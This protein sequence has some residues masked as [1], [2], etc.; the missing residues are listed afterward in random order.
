M[1]WLRVVSI[2][3]LAVAALQASAAAGPVVTTRAGA[4]RGVAGY[5]DVFRGIP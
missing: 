5:P 4:V 1:M 2:S 3:V